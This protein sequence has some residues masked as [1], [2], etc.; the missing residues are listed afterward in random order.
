MLLK[1]G[2]DLTLELPLGPEPSRLVGSFSRRAR[3]SDFASVLRYPGA[4]QTLVRFRR[5][6][7][8]GYRVYSLENGPY[9]RVTRQVPSDNDSAS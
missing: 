9:T 1:K 3:T 6:E 2:C 7:T 8:V 4:S 5:V